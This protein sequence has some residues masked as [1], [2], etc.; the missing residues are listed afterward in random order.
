MMRFAAQRC[1][2][3]VPLLFVVSFLVFGFVF[4]VPGDPAVTLAGQGATPEQIAATRTRLGVD[5]PLGEQYF[6]WLGNALHGD[7]GR[8]LFGSTN[9]RSL[10]GG[11]LPATLSLAGGAL[12]VALA[13]GIPVGIVAGTHRGGVIDRVVTT[14]ATVGLA[15]PAF[16]LGMLLILLLSIR[17]S[18]FPA[19]GYV[20]LTDDPAEWLR[21]I[22][23]P[24]I[25]LGLAP[26]AE[27]ARQ[28]RSSI[29]GV[30]GKPHIETARAK[31]LPWP[32]VVRRHTL[33]NASIPVT[34]V[35]G[36]QAALLLGGVVVIE[37][38]FAIPGLGQVA[39]TAVLQRDLPVIQGVALFVT[40]VVVLINLVVDL[41]HG[42]LDPRIRS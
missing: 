6:H 2:T 28:L 1:L 33:R 14:L 17:F 32:S 31:G 40:V 5:A 29:A 21:H 41:S 25:A 38:L 20:G 13:V 18:V 3:A 9:V 36:F 27:I 23:L 12:F 8:S 10:I 30:L 11:A 24:S 35:V 15:V 19:Q 22:V 16:W 7:L 42:W 4:L 34:T 26:A 37:Q 39:V